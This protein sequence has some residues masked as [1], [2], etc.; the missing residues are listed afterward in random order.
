MTAAFMLPFFSFFA[1]TRKRAY[2]RGGLPQLLSLFVLLLVSTGIVVGC[3]SNMA[4][5][6]SATAPTTPTPTTPAAPTTPTGVQMVTVTATSGAI[7][8]QTTIAV[9]VQ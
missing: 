9:T 6:T 5:T 4:P 8:Q 2:G 3:S 1:F 7:T